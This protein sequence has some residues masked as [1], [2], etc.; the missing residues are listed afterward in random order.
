MQCFTSITNNYIP[1]A[2]VL[3]RTL[4]SHHPDWKLHLVLSEPLHPSVRPFE[5]PFDSIINID[6]LG[7]PNLQSW[8]FKHRVT[9]I[10]TAVKGL[11]AL[12]IIERENADRIIYFDPDIAVFNDLSHLNDLLDQ[13]PILLAPHQSKPEHAKHSI[14]ANEI[15]SLRWGVFNLGFFAARKD[16]QGGEFLKWWSERLSQFCYDDIPYGLFTDQRWCDLAPVFFDQL[17]ILR[18][19]QFDVATWNLT[20]RTMTMSP[21]G[22]LQIDGKPLGFY[23]FSG[24]DSEAGFQMVRHLFQDTKHPIFD[25]WEWYLDQIRIY[26]QEELGNAAWQYAR[27]SNGAKIEDA[28]R[29]TYRERP[30]LETAFPNPF[31][32][33]EGKDSFYAWWQHSQLAGAAK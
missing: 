3:A 5:E 33:E 10:C 20:Q 13:H 30:D 19:P 28:M 22:Q 9:E 32:V 21:E 4:K 17:H 31:R 11:A 24:Y 26:G 16:G 6:E 2:R 23:H 25:V 29:K 15:G 7:I 14:V 27:F 18:D 12:W 1:K 8:I